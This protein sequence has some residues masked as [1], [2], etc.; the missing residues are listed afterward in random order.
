[1]GCARV[2]D[3]SESTPVYPTPSRY[4]VPNGRKTRTDSI[5]LRQLCAHHVE[6][7]DPSTLRVLR[8]VEKP[9]NPAA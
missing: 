1:M 4:C 6:G 2:R 8:C 5:L 9:I 7:H 3:V